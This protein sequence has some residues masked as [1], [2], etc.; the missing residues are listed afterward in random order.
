MAVFLGLNK[1]N[2]RGRE[3]ATEEDGVSQRRSRVCTFSAFEAVR[4]LLSH[5]DHFKS[6]HGLL[7]HAVSS[8]D[9][10]PCV[11]AAVN[12]FEVIFKLSD[13]A[14]GRISASLRSECNTRSKWKQLLYLSLCIAMQALRVS[15]PDKAE[16]LDEIAKTLKNMAEQLKLKSLREDSENALKA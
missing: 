5:G 8:E 10:E 15:N 7:L 9:M 14:V 13:A 2:K 16:E 12:I 6:R 11:L 1:N 3:T 4:Y